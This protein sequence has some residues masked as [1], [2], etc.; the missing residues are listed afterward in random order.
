MFDCV[1]IG[2]C[3]VDYLC[4]LAHYPKLDEKLDAEQF[5]YQGGG[6]VPTAMVTLARLGAKTSYI[7][8]VGDDHNGRFLLE[9][10]KK[11]G[12]DTSA[13]IVDKNCTTN[14]AFIWIDNHT[15]KKSIVLSRHS[16]TV[17]LLP[18]EIS[19]KHVTSTKFLHVDAREVEAT[20]KAIQLAKKAG[21]K[22]VLDAGSKRNEINK[23][24]KLVDY[25]IVSESFCHS[26]LKT[27]NYEEGLAKLLKMGAKTAV[28][29]CGENGCYGSDKSGVFYQPAFKVDVVDTTGAGDVFH[30]AFIYGLLQNWHL[31]EQLK[32]AAATAAI[33]CTQLGG[34]AG[35]PN[36]IEVNK[37]LDGE[38]R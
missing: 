17:P 25:P 21:V 33:K 35:I 18:D 30:G 6:P 24:L 15:G 5:S 28:I 19:V 13:V 37:F 38:E 34:R 20:L 22:V 11:E 16:S 1:G 29:T 10:F 32:F 2:I 14:Q 27:Q 26:Y 4:L 9:Q 3:A 7:G 31:A 36:L 12:V 23:I 8:I